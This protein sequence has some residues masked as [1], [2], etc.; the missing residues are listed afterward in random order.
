[1]KGSALV[2][3]LSVFS[4][5]AAVAWAVQFVPTGQTAL[6]VAVLP[7]WVVLL[8]ILGGGSPGPKSLVGVL[9][10]FGG[11]A[12]L[13]WPSFADQETLS[14]FP[15]GIVLLGSL[16]N[17]IGIRLSK[18]VGLPASTFYHSALSQL[19]GALPFA[20]LA[21]LTG[22]VGRTHW[23]SVTAS[24]WMA[25]GF[26]VVFGSCAG[27]SAFSWLA[28]NT[29]A[30]LMSTYAFVNPVIAVLLGTW[31]A[32]EALGPNLL[33]GGGLVII[34]VVLVLFDSGPSPSLSFLGKIPKMLGLRPAHRVY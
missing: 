3:F 4:F 13:C 14:F 18:K 34:A 28:R 24:S 22:E 1:M 10:G 9:V 11:I 6:I 12:W 17:A 21:L 31:L 19:V 33:I 23:D 16:L 32:H 2:G 5:N 30:R 7:L 20:S 26:L 29:E 15:Q 27:F 8:E 25:L